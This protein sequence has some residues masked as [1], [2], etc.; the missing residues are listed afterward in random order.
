VVG[1]EGRARRLVPHVTVPT[2]EWET[3]CAKH[4]EVRGVLEAVDA[5]IK[6][7]RFKQS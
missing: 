2:N 7:A 3:F 6:G 1:A 5:K 4:A